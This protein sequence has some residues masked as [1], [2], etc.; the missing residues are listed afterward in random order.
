MTAL[1]APF[2]LKR[3]TRLT[4]TLSC[5]ERNAC[6]EVPTVLLVSGRKVGSSD[7]VTYSLDSEAAKVY[8][9]DTD[10]PIADN[11]DR[12]HSACRQRLH[13][14][15]TERK[16]TIRLNL[17]ESTPFEPINLV[18]NLRRRDRTQARVGF[19]PG[20]GSGGGPRD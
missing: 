7:T 17:C 9:F 15:A 18:F 14:K 20:V 19:D 12:E 11:P 4:L 13:C 8:Q 5:I 1:H 16:L 3:E 2:P 10:T 6:A